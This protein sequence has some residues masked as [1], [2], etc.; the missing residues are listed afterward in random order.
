[1]ELYLV[2]HGQAVTKEQNPESPSQRRWTGGG[3]SDR[4]DSEKLGIEVTEIR[5]SDKLRAMQTAEEI[6]RAL[7][8]KCHLSTG[9]GPKDDVQPLVSELISYRDNLMIV[10]HLPFVSRLALLLVCGDANQAVVEFKMAGIVRLD[11]RKDGS[12]ALIW[13]IPPEIM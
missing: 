3:V 2:Q 9:L 5:H 12:W 4:G 11:R 6:G 8:T 7:E 10:G 13:N 1:M